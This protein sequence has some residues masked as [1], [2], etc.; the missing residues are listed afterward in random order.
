[1]CSFH[2]VPPSLSASGT[3]FD[4]TCV[5]LTSAVSC[6]VQVGNTT[7]WTDVILNI[8]ATNRT[9]IRVGHF[10]RIYTPPY[11]GTI[12]EYLSY[13]WPGTPL[14]SDMWAEVF[15]SGISS[16]DNQFFIEVTNPTFDV[17]SNQIE[18]EVDI[19]DHDNSNI[20]VS[21]SYIVIENSADL[22]IE[23]DLDVETVEVGLD[24]VNGLVKIEG[25]PNSN[26]RS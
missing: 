5:K 25:V 24:E 26:L 23:E 14:Q 4:C 17:T 19:A 10:S 16:T 15:I 20:Q 11:S 6:T 13:P 12:N 21:Y 9:D 3:N 18:F 1:M 8:V 2:S 7:G 22:D